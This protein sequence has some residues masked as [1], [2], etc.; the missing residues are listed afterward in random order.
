[1]S[2]STTHPS[3]QSDTV[4]MATYYQ[5]ANTL[6]NTHAYS[7]TPTELLSTA[8]HPLS[9]YGIDASTTSYSHTHQTHPAVHTQ[10]HYT[11]TLQNQVNWPQLAHRYGHMAG[12]AS[13]AADY[14]NNR[15]FSHSSNSLLPTSAE[16]NGGNPSAHRNI[17]QTATPTTYQEWLASSN[18]PTITTSTSSL[19]S[20]NNSNG[21]SLNPD[22]SSM[23][24][25]VSQ[26]D[27]QVLPPSQKNQNGLRVNTLNRY[28]SSVFHRTINP[29]PPPNTHGDYLPQTINGTDIQNS[30]SNSP[31]SFSDISVSTSDMVQTLPHQSLHSQQHHS[32]LHQQSLHN[33]CHQLNRLNSPVASNTY[34][35]LPHPALDR[36]GSNEDGLCS[37]DPDSSSP[38]SLMNGSRAPYDWMRSAQM[39]NNS[40]IRKAG[41]TRTKDKYR[42][43][44]SDYQ[45]LEL[46][47]E[48]H[49]NL[50]INVIRKAELAQELGLSQRQIKIWFQNRRA[51]ARKLRQREKDKEHIK[52]EPG[53]NDSCLSVEALSPSP[54][55]P[56]RMSGEENSIA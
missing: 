36:A 15:L 50:Y 47:K 11:P 12:A 20:S 38:N 48:F 17:R 31:V 30:L 41:R 35:Q 32:S 16:M 3:L 8:F 33:T 28:P 21:R 23:S 24:T 6:Y 56:S 55:S 18:Q 43:V 22:T 2:S 19:K 51:K 53:I 34:I 7:G 10:A 4:L 14:N 25:L 37:S 52:S 49:Y 26:H 5:K 42:V 27:Q 46:E 44:Y 40:K 13:V 54:H 9:S 29:S 45:R 39:E 1:M